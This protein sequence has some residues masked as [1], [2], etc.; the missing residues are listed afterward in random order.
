M[1]HP[2]KP[3]LAAILRA[4]I[5]VSKQVAECAPPRVFDR[6][7]MLCTSRLPTIVGGTRMGWQ[8]VWPIARERQD[9]AKARPPPSDENT[10]EPRCM[11]PNRWHNNNNTQERWQ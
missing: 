6:Q 7:E 4:S 8:Q 3:T 1:T 5:E 9:Q 2:H 10:D 11:S